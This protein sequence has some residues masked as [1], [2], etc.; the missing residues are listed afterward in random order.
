[1]NIK[2]IILPIISKNYCPICGH[3]ARG[4]ITTGTSAEI[5]ERLKGVGAG[6]RKTVCPY[7]RS[8]DRERLV[9]LYLRDFYL[10]N[11][12]NV[13]IKCLH[14][15]PEHQLSL[16]LQKTPIIDYIAADKRCEGY[17]Y[18]NYV[19]DIDIMQ[20]YDI[21]DKTFDL[22]IC[23]HVLEH[24]SNDIIAMQ[25]LCRIL[26]DNGIAILQVPIALKLDK[27]IDD[28]TITSPKDRFEKYG[29]EDH[30]R[31]YGIDYPE[32]LKKAGFRVEVINI[33]NRYPRKFGLN[34][35]EMLYI[36]HK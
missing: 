4:F 8:N 14:V 27:T 26:K 25:E 21:Q 19:K 13:K 31:I 2:K 10:P 34:K 24:V 11:K 15:A 18:P 12:K 7:C 30:V 16:Y 5:W 17:E 36:C 35:N 33:A 22:V 20:M 32:R 1:M 29:Q 9:F 23:N 28:P 3:Y 6:L